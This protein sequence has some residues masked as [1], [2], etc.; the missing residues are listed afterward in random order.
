MVCVTGGI[1]AN[2]MIA[3]DD[4]FFTRTFHERSR[5]KREKEEE[6]KEL[7]CSEIWRGKREED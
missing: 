5:D 1:F 4:L 2:R 6:Y 3:I 7:P